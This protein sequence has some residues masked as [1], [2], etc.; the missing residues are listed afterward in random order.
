MER[1]KEVSD[2]AMATVDR[3]VPVYPIG[4]VERLTGL[5]AR[6]IR[7]Y[8]KEGILRP[9]RTRGNRRLYSP[10]EVERL[11][12]VKALMAQGLNLEGVRA[13]LQSQEGQAQEPPAGA[14]RRTPVAEPVA[15]AVEPLVPAGARAGR[16]AA[17]RAAEAPRPAPEELDHAEIIEHLRGRRISSLFPVDNQAELTRWLASSREREARG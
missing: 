5:T 16:G 9:N 11:R 14:A 8:E 12:Q 4:V 13:Y 10:A 6:Q 2:D 15:A 3:S 7:Y 17:A 1:G